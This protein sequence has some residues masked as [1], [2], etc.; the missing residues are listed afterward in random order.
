MP[1]TP[2]TW[3]LDTTAVCGMRILCPG[4]IRWSLQPV[5]LVASKHW[6]SPWMGTF[7]CGRGEAL[8]RGCPC[9]QHKSNIQPSAFKSFKMTQGITLLAPANQGGHDPKSPPGSEPQCGCAI[10]RARGGRSAKAVPGGPACRRPEPGA[11]QAGRTLNSSALTALW[12]RGAAT[13]SPIPALQAQRL[14]PAK[15]LRVHL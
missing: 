10:A 9:G 5:E 15:A 2:Y 13:R 14:V 8:V 12:G 11:G 4:G 6:L 3:E 7:R 1:R